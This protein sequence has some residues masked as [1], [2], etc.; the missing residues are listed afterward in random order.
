MSSVVD[1]CNQALGWLGS[2]PIISLEDDTR[3][4]QL[5]KLNFALVRDAVTEEGAWTFC[6]A[7]IALNPDPIRPATQ[8]GGYLYSYKIPTPASRIL[9]VTDNKEEKHYP[10]DFSYRVEDRYIL[11]NEP[12][13]IYVKATYKT[14][15]PATWSAG[16]KQ[17]VAQRLAAD[18]AIPLTRDK[19]L[20]QQMW[21]LYETKLE[22]A[23]DMDN[24]QG[25]ND[26]PNSDYYI[27]V[28]RR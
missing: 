17:A 8:S 24:A 23:L 28:R 26:R 11:C 13:T 4:A 14:I 19:A 3:E 9:E 15:D 12:D 10:N 1:I 6:T 18:L 20:Q 16:F 27:R 21:A 2:N 22:R 25:T 5:C 7:R